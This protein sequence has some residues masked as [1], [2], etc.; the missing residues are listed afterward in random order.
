MIEDKIKEILKNKKCKRSFPIKDCKPIK[1]PEKQGL[2]VAAG[3]RIYALEGD[4]RFKVNIIALRDNNVNKL[5]YNNNV[6][7]DLSGSKIR[8][9]LTDKTI[10]K[11]GEEIIGAAFRKEII[12]C[13]SQQKIYDTSNKKIVIDST[14]HYIRNLISHNGRLYH[15][16]KDESGFFDTL[17]GKKITTKGYGNSMKSLISHKNNL[18]YSSDQYGGKFI[19]RIKNV[20]DLLSSKTSPDEIKESN[21]LYIGYDYDDFNKQ[22]IL[23][24]F[25]EGDKLYHVSTTCIFET[26]NK[27]IIANR[28]SHIDCIKYHNGKVLDSSLNKIFDTYKDQFGQNPLM[29]FESEIKDMCN[30]PMSLFNKFVNKGLVLNNNSMPSSPHY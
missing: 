16:Q 10:F 12:Y 20:D 26:I 28:E 9:T 11:A 13:N 17:S 21:N 24:L 4:E 19:I 7:Y 14:S 5:L 3:K 29:I 1:K 22:G 8:D 6:L 30:V 15:I 2:I 18:Y 23:N 25:S 27:K